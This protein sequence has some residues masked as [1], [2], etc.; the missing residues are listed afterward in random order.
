MLTMLRKQ[1]QSTVIQIMV[2]AIIIVFV[3]WGVGTNFMNKRNSVAVV[4]GEDIPV[5]DFQSSYDRA[6]ENYRQQFGGSIP[7]DI[8]KKMDLKRQVLGQLIRGELLRQGGRAMGIPVSKLAIQL[9]IKN[10]PVFQQNGRFDMKRYKAVLAQNRMTPASFEEGLRHD[11]LIQRVSDSIRSFALVDDSEVQSRIDYANEEVK[12]AYVVMKGEDFQDKVEVKDKDLAAWY[13]RHKE[14]YL[15][16]PQIRLKYLYFDF[17]R[18]MNNIKL[19]DGAVKARYEAEKAKFIVP[20]QRH[21]LHI[22]F[23]VSRT[24]GNQ[25][26]EAEKKKA[27]AVLKLVRGGMDFAAAARKYSEGPTAATG[28][29]LGFFSRG[30]MVKSFDDV[31]FSLKPGEISGVVESPFGYHIIKLVAVRP[32]FIR[33]FDQVKGEIA[34]AMKRQQAKAQ[35]FKRA[36]AAYEDIIRS[37]SLKKYSQSNK[38]EKV[39]ET[40]YFTRSAPPKTIVADPKFLQTAFRLKKGELSSLVETGK[41]YAILFVD[42][43]R[44]PVVPALKTVRDRVEADYRKEK[45]VELARQAARSL[46]KAA[47]EKKGLAAVVSKTAR[48]QESGYLK[49]SAAGNGIPSQVVVQAFSL[50]LKN[51][52]P[53]EPVA[54]GSEF[55]VFQLKERREGAAKINEA[56][57]RQ[58]KARLLASTQSRLLMDWLAYMQSKSKIWT[59]SQILQ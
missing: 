54:V 53:K 56:Q 26:R 6:L 36:S 32:A 38:S 9:K 29:D 47:R 58:L 20:E 18:Y 25:V 27:E 44:E 43:I 1:A 28:G 40:G 34:A 39:I 48:L 42:D 45:G 12:L 51:P 16:E 21:A 50:S 57:R 35:A 17:D 15:P 46:L 49:R 3:F 37:G 2:L 55:Y 59:N 11:L 52:L 30:R 8:L 31:V 24:A 33:S 5:R 10:M 41:G 7:R 19:A 13:E 22:F 14:A 4:N 23:K